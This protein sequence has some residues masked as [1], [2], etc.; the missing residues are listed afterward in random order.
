[1]ASAIRLA[2]VRYPV[3]EK[4]VIRF[5]R[6]RYP[7]RERPFRSTEISRDLRTL[8]PVRVE[9][10]S[11]PARASNRCWGRRGLLHIHDIDQILSAQRIPI[12]RSLIYGPQETCN[13]PFDRRRNP[14]QWACGLC[15]LAQELAPLKSARFSPSAL[16]SAGQFRNCRGMG[17]S[18]QFSSPNRAFSRFS[19]KP[20]QGTGDRSKVAGRSGDRRLPRRRPPDGDASDSFTAT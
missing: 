8:V 5:G 17:V 20:R 13:R 12:E 3:R 14:G 6:K 16:P 1:M 15:P 2:K 7:F 4:K 10:A 19:R 11:T 9:R 18:C